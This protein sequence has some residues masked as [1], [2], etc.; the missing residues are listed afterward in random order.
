[1]GAK[2]TRTTFAIGITKVVTCKRISISFHFRIPPGM[3]FIPDEERL[4]T[5]D[6][7]VKNREYL[8]EQHARLPVVIETE[9]LKTRKMELETKL[10]EIEDSI[11]LFSRPKLLVSKDDYELM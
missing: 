5:L 7:L 6:K 9:S 10:L 3:M 2:R 8:M 4:S 1:M 11:S